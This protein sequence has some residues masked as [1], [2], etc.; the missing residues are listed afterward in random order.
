MIDRVIIHIK[1][2]DG[3]NGAISGRREKYVPRG[4]PDGGDGGRGGSVYLV[5]DENVNTLLAYRYKRHF[6]AEDG[7]RGDGKLKHG[8]DGGDVT[9]PVPLGTQVWA[10]DGGQPRMLADIGAD[11]ERW[12]AAE[13][14]RG[15]AGNARYATSTNRFPR[16][17]QSGEPGQRRTLRLELKLLADVGIVGAPNAGKSSLL[18]A[19]SAARPKVA[20]YAFTTLEPSLGV[21]ERHGETFV[22]VDIPGLIEGASDGVGLGHEFLRHVERT[23]VLI[24]LVDGADADP[25]GV[26]ERIGEE[27]A[28]YDARLAQKPRLLAVN[29]LDLP[30][31][32]E[33]REDLRDAFVEAS[34]GAEPLFV[35]AATREGVDDLLDAALSALK[36]AREAPEPPPSWDADGLP[37]LRPAPRRRRPVVSVDADGG[38]AVD[39]QPAER[40]AAMVGA[41]DWAAWIQFYARL[42]RAGVMRALEEA[43]AGPGDVVR[44]GDAEWVWEA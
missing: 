19:V 6:S 42:E 11:G 24:H 7:R 39:W 26:Y 22:M 8:G 34:G 18:A 30:D 4:G 31:V 44:I 10:D 3:G 2:G 43:G 17:A 15:G 1:S 29:K 40:M 38:Y 32:W 27:L 41:D 12:L 36:A 23:R 14:G 20:D 28:R 16:L 35:S 37:T 13:G 9:L 21:V 25:I 33:L 5:G